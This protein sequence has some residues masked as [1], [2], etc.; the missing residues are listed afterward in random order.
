MAF[1]ATFAFEY[2]AS[3]VVSVVVLLGKCEKIGLIKCVVYASINW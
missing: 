2:L 1:E 3:N